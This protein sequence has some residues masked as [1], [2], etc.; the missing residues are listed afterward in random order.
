MFLGSVLGAAL[1]G[2]SG[3]GKTTLMDVICGRK[4]EG[5]M[6]GE[7][8]VNGKPKV[9]SAFRK[10]AGY[11]EQTDLHMPF[12]TVHESLMFSAK[13][14]LPSNVTDEQRLAFVSEIEDML[15]LAPLRDRIIGNTNVA[16]LAPGQLKL[17]TM[18]VELCANPAIMCLDVSED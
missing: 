12:Y 10:L 16:G 14:R 6:E 15:E 5:V 7:I 3:A 4:T 2:S 17:V 13:L 11:V 9:D 1:M 18:G 8:L